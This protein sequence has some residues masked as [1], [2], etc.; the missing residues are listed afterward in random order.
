[1]AMESAVRRSL[2]FSHM[3]EIEVSSRHIA[4]FW[5]HV[6]TACIMLCTSVGVYAVSTVVSV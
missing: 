6:Y 3:L 4:T 5:S 2:I 1:M